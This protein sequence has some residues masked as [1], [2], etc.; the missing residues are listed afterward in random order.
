MLRCNV[1]CDVQGNAATSLKA[2]KH[3]PCYWLNFP[4][5]CYVINHSVTLGCSDNILM[6]GSCFFSCVEGWTGDW[7]QFIFWSNSLSSLVFASLT[8][9]PFVSGKQGII[10]LEDL[11]HEIYSVGKGFRAAN[12]F[13]LPFRLSVPRHA[14]RDK[15][16]I[17]KDLGNPGFRGSD[18]NSI[19][20]LLNWG[21]PRKRAASSIV[22]TSSKTKR[23]LGILCLFL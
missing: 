14:A 1:P 8:H 19:I 23:T 11:I 22:R 21:L 17:L 20:R 5:T 18:I 10:C 3:Q 16:G 12:N 2:C 9:L 13:L 15:A 7:W 6:T 4:W